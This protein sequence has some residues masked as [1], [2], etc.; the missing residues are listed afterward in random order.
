MS[1][2]LTTDQRRAAL[3]GLMEIDSV[4]ITPLQAAPIIGCA[5]YA[6]N[7]DVRE[8]MEN[9]G[10]VRRFPFPVIQRGRQVKI[11]RLKFIEYYKKELGMVEEPEKLEGSA[12][13][14]E[15]IAKRT[16]ELLYGML[17]SGEPIR[18]EVS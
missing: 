4:Y 11:N 10:E 18:T 13:Y 5:A 7:L 3:R 9:F 6:I 2:P 1:T 16:A 12:E 14:I 15:A 17:T 8:D